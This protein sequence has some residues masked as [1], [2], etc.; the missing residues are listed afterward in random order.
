M[1]TAVDGDLHGESVERT[2]FGQRDDHD[3]ELGYDRRCDRY[4][5]GTGRRVT[6]RLTWYFTT[7]NWNSVRTVTVVGQLGTTYP[8]AIR[9]MRLC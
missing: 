9:T 2:V 4:D 3:G 8:T 5:V 6:T 1:R 7:S